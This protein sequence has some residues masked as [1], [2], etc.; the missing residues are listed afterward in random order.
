MGNTIQC[1]THGECE[2]T[3]VCSHLVGKTA[4]LGFNRNEPSEDDPFPNA[5][6]D[7][8]E[9]IR[10]AHHGWN[11]ESE[12]LT[13]IQLLCSGCYEQARMR[14]TRTSTTLEDLATFRWKCG[15]CEEWHTGACLDFSYPSPYYWHGS[16]EDVNAEQLLD[17][18]EL[19]K[20]FLDEDFCAI[21]G[22]DFFVRGSIHLPIFG[23]AETFR[24]GVW[25]SLSHESFETL[26]RMIEDPKRVDLEP[27]FSWLSSQIDGYPDTLNLKMY[28]HVQELGLRPIFELE[29]TE[30]P[31][32]REHHRG[33]SAER[34]KEIMLSRLPKQ[35]LDD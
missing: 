31:L 33:I 13:T 27:M 9:L 5:W 22:R 16:A 35:E 1:P 7:D 24:W 8:C 3:F 21:D 14:N 15:S 4:G 34:V 19:P 25:G 12:K 32:S 30:H 18:G 6:C 2:E 23:T 17:S 29:A 20:T 11:E 28:L 10:A 26:L